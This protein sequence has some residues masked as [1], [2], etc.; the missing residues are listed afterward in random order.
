MSAEDS[1][2]SDDS[3][4]VVDDAD[5]SESGTETPMVESADDESKLPHDSETSDPKLEV[6][7]LHLLA[8]QRRGYLCYDNDTSSFL[9]FGEDDMPADLLKNFKAT[10]RDPELRA[11][12]RGLTQ[13][14]QANYQ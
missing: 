7:K 1:A 4:E 3:D 5:V 13:M 9:I 6:V 12:R 14:F 11:R 10:Q 2:D 8:D